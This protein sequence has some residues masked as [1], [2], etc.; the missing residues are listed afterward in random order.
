VF[1]NTIICC[2]SVGTQ[3]A[4]TTGMVMWVVL[5]VVLNSF[6]VV[7]M[8]TLVIY[9]QE[10]D[11]VQFVVALKRI[12]KRGR[13]EADS[14]KSSR[15]PIGLEDQLTAWQVNRER[16]SKGP[17]GRVGKGFAGVRP[18]IRNSNKTTVPGIFAAFEGV[19]TKNVYD[20]SP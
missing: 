10:L 12:F 18:G 11:D 16:N 6:T 3:I 5:T 1:A 20:G 9:T 8:E 2:I 15:P 4:S 14:K 19:V 17:A 13:S 7:H